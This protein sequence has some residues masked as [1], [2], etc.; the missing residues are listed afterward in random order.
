MNI[1]QIHAAWFHSL[2]ELCCS[3]GPLGADHGGR[4]GMAFAETSCEA[5]DNKQKGLAM[6]QAFKK[7]G[8]GG[9]I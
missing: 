4:Q 2:V 8:C 6:R 9:R 1:T 7:F 3:G 5:R